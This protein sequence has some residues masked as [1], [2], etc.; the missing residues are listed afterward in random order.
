MNCRQIVILMLCVVLVALAGTY[1]LTVSPAPRTVSSSTFD[2]KYV[3]DGSAKSVGITYTNA[4]G[5][6]EQ[7]STVRLPFVLTFTAPEGQ[8]L[9]ISAQNDGNLGSVSCHILLDGFEQRSAVS[10]GAYVI[11]SCSGR[12]KR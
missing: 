2:V 7:R 5:G 1:L 9:S 11:A 3:I 6:I 12:F 4:T 10:S 8:F